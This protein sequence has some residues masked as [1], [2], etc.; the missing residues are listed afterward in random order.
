M[1]KYGGKGTVLQLSI[2]AVYTTIGQNIS[3]DG[4]DP[5]VEDFESTDLSTGVGRAYQPT[6]YV[7]GGMVTGEGFLDPVAATFQAL[8]DLLTTPAVSSWKIIFPDAAATE[9]SF[10][11]ILKKVK[12]KVVRTDG[13]KFDYALKL[14]GIVSYPT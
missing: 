5:D 11:A 7:D 14:S 13:L 4:P 2:A 12:P 6:G 8:T 9:W 1:A 10:S 3:I